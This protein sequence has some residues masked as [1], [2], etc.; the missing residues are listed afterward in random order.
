MI[1]YVRAD[2]TRLR[3]RLA[4]VEQQ[5]M[6]QHLASLRD[7]EKSF[8]A[9]TSSGNSCTVPMRPADG[10]YPSDILHLLRFNG[11][12]P[13][14]DAVTKAGGV[15]AKEIFSFPGGR[16]FHFIDPSGNELAVWSE[17]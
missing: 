11:G 14:F 2:C 3:A 17:A 9:M 10:A 7:L 1:D 16:R 4:P 5:K 12:E 6:D 13:A 15:I 8:S